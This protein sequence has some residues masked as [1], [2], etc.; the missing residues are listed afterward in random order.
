MMDAIKAAVF[1]L[2]LP[3]AMTIE[4]RALFSV[5]KLEKYDELEQGLENG[6]TEFIKTLEN[7]QEIDFS[8]FVSE[9]FIQLQITFSKMQQSV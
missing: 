9:T 6:F 3:L 8:S 7:P 1:L 2:L 5:L 4:F